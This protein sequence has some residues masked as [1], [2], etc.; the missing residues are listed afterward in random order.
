[1]N[2]VLEVATVRPTVARGVETF[3]PTE[4]QCHEFCPGCCH[5]EAH[6][7]LVQLRHL[8]PQRASVMNSV[9][10][11]ATVRPTVGQVS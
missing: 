3:R 10:E 11:V 6:S 4:G 7:G 5:S 1:M 9:L 8:G 2:S